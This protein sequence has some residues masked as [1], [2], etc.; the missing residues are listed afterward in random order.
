MRGLLPITVDDGHI[1]IYIVIEFD[2][3]FDF[4]MVDCCGG[5]EKI[6]GN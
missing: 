6:D 3:D 2:M 4:G 5:D 1:F